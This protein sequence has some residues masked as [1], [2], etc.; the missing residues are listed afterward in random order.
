MIATRFVL[1][2]RFQLTRRRRLK[3][4]LSRVKLIFEIGG[5]FSDLKLRIFSLFRLK[6]AA[7][8]LIALVTVSS[9]QI[10]ASVP[11][12][13]TS[14]STGERQLL[15]PLALSFTY[16]AANNSRISSDASY[17]DNYKRARTLSPSR[18]S[19]SISDY[20]F[21]SVLPSI[22]SFKRNHQIVS[23]ISLLSC[24][25]L[26]ATLSYWREGSIGWAE[27]ALGASAWLVSEALKEGIFELFTYKCYSDGVLV[28]N[29]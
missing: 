22:H 29:V 15:N 13:S 26:F 23:Y 2:V 10:M 24:V 16:N 27:L 4:L 1:T 6:R 21:D 5:C 11:H 19:I 20:S 3:L 28:S 12:A 17:E 18:D 8:I 9:R 7:L 25:L 14:S